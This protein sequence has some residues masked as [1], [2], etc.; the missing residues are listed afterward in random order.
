[1]LFKYPN[2][3]LLVILYLFQTDWCN[4]VSI[5]G[6]LLVL[7]CLERR[8]VGWG[9]S[10]LSRLGWGKVAF[11]SARFLD[12]LL[13]VCYPSCL[14]GDV[15]K[16][17]R[18]LG[19]GFLPWGGAGALVSR[20]WLQQQGCL[21]GSLCPAAFP[22]GSPATGVLCSEQQW[23]AE[24]CVLGRVSALGVCAEYGVAAGRLPFAGVF[25]WTVRWG[26]GWVLQ[27]HWVFWYY[28]VLIRF[29]CRT[30]N[31]TGWVKKKIRELVVE[32]CWAL[33]SVPGLAQQYSP[34]LLGD[35]WRCWRLTELTGEC[36]QYRVVPRL[37]AFVYVWDPI[38][39]EN[40]VITETGPEFPWRGN[41]D[42]IA[43][44]G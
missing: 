35:C 9:W 4:P 21:L 12:C 22:R 24:C 7:R 44:A 13:A 30:T 3:Q 25:W 27:Y 15:G 14:T 17:S 42:F 16:V 18:E 41:V 10:P 36:Q 28:T 23:E 39:T 8:S 38:S 37:V 43:A 6:S 20:S 5:V 40:S 19:F 34:E 1:M 31:L 2:F 29:R 33:R 32:P 26:V 11:G